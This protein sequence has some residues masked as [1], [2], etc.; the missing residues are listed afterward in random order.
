MIRKLHNMKA[1]RKNKELPLIIPLVSLGCFFLLLSSFYCLSLSSWSSRSFS[2]SQP[3]ARHEL[4]AKKVLHVPASLSRPFGRLHPRPCHSF[5]F[6]FLA[7]AL[8]TTPPPFHHQHHQF[9]KYF[10]DEN[11][12]TKINKLE[13]SDF[14]L[15]R[16]WCRICDRFWRRAGCFACVVSLL[17]LL[18][19]LCCCLLRC[20]SCLL[21]FLLLLL[22]ETHPDACWLDKLK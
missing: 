8:C 5:S 9:K 19:L 3:S 14:F 7:L 6:A 21:L 1:A 13:G 15:F 4:F 20:C 10:Y 2:T 18:L 12:S 16:L 11:K 17:L 22:T